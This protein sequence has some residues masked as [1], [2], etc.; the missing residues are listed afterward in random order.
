[1]CSSPYDCTD[2]LA[3]Y[4]LCLGDHG[5]VDLLSMCPP[6]GFRDGVVGDRFRHGGHLQQLI[7]GTV[8]GMHL[9]HIEPPLGERPRLVEHHR[10][11][12]GEGL[13]VVSALHE[14][15]QFGCGPYAA[16]VSQGYGDHQ[17]TRAG[18][19]QE[20]ERPVYPCRHILAKEDGDHRDHDRTCDHDGCVVP[21]E[22]RDEPLRRCLGGEGLLHQFEHL[23]YRGVLVV[24][25]HPDGDLGREVHGTA[26][27]LVP[28]KDVPGQ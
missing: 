16:E 20:R 7:L 21:C 5:G 3:G 19:D 1:M 22:L 4:L 25:G 14:D 23:R 18:D 15:P 13:Q 2:P 8:H 10:V 6:D 26:H 11:R 12:L 17:C 28:G 27:D 9:H 24:P